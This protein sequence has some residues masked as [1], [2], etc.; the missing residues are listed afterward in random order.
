MWED[1]E[2]DHVK[3]FL[4]RY[5]KFLT[6]NGSG[7]FVGKGFTWA[8]AV[9]Y[10]SFSN[11]TMRSPQLLTPYPKL[12]EFLKKIESHPKIKAWIDKRPKTEM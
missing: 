10:V 4:D 5:T 9:L 7:Y 2:K 11:W 1:L 8:D 3:P 12:Q 6:D